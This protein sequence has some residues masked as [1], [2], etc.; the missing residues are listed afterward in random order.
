MPRVDAD[1]K[2]DFK[3]VLLRPKRS[4]LK[5]RSEVGAPGPGVLSLWLSAP[6][7]LP[8]NPPSS[9]LSLPALF[10]SPR[11]NVAVPSPLETPFACR[12]GDGCGW[13]P[14]LRAGGGRGCGATPL[15]CRKKRK[16]M[17]EKGCRGCWGRCLLPTGASAGSQRGWGG[18]GGF[19][20]HKAR[21]CM[22]L[23][24]LPARVGLH[25]PAGSGG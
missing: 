21:G 6:L 13:V 20:P 19:V 14:P 4:S 22:S 5:S 23:L 16:K 8:S 25:V 15:F 3:D 12:G 7:C 9:F 17:K 11:C 10:L 24:L 2:L 1:L 18:R